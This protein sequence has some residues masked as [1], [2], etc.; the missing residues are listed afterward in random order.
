TP[1]WYIGAGPSITFTLSEK[2]YTTISA[3]VSSLWFYPK[4][5]RDNSLPNFAANV[6]DNQTLATNVDI[7][8][9]FMTSDKISL[10][11]FGGVFAGNSSNND[12]F[13]D[14]NSGDAIDLV[15]STGVTLSYYFGKENDTDGDGIVDSKDMCPN[16]PKGVK[17]DDFGCPLDK[18]G[19]G[20]AD[21][22][23]KCPDTP[24]GVKVDSDGCPLDTDEDGVADYLDKCPDTPKGVKVDSDGCPLDTDGDGVADYL[25]KCPDTLTGVKVDSDGCPLD[26]DGDGVADYLDKCPDTPKGDKVDKYGCSVILPVIFG[27]DANFALNSSK[28][29]RES[30]SSLDQLAEKMNTNQQYIAIVEGYTDTYGQADYNMK[31]SKRRAESVVNYLVNKGVERDRFTVKPFGETN[32]VASNKTKEGRA[33]NRRVVVKLMQ[34]N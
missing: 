2:V 9:R 32:P 20:V 27:A 26:T 8:L 23:D 33:K 12:Y 4:D 16:T 21:Y 25:D 3:G 19:D 6:Y 11:L 18:D 13:D 28:L 30:Y 14:L 22:L 1:F 31:L 17:V 5:I 29:S 10:N 34:K 15:F 7:N 24:K